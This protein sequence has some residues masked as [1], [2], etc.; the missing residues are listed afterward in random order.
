MP[1]KIILTVG[2]FVASTMLMLLISIAS[3]AFLEMKSELST[4]G[5]GIA[6]N[7][8]ATNDLTTQ[9]AV[10]ETSQ[11]DIKRLE[12]KVDQLQ[13][14]FTAHLTKEDIHDQGLKPLRDEVE[15]HGRELERLRDRE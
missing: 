2:G 1:M 12:V 7:T 10:L 9:V 13:A 8:S 3:W 11:E 4:L 5:E 14:Q 15:R 6:A